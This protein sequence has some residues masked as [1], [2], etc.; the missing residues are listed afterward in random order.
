MR[1]FQG[2]PGQSK[3]NEGHHH[4]QVDKPVKDVEP[5]ENFAMGDLGFLRYH[6]LNP[7]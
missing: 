3:A 1:I 4:H 5:P 2:K 7:F 6:C